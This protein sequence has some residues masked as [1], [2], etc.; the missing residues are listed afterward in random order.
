M[1]ELVFKGLLKAL[2]DLLKPIWEAAGVKLNAPEWLD[3]L[4]T[5]LKKAKS[6][7]FAQLKSIL[8]EL[9][10]EVT[11]ERARRAANLA[12][13]VSEYIV[14]LQ[15]Q[16]T[17]VRETSTGW[18]IDKLEL[19]TK[20]GA[21]A[22]RIAYNREPLT[23]WA[24]VND[25][26]RLEKLERDAHA[27]LTRWSIPEPDL[28]GV[29]NAAYVMCRATAKT[30]LIPMTEFYKS[31]R[32]VQVRRLLDSAGPHA[33]LSK[34]KLPVASFLHSV[35]RYRVISGDLP[36]AE[37]LGFQTGSSHEV[38]QKKGFIINGLDASSEYKVVCYVVQAEQ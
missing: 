17:L 3:E 24:N 9:D 25:V 21:G 37:R 8:D 16:G 28:L 15:A 13:I 22:A 2:G 23:P 19:Q 11:R 31:I 14:K 36:I 18:R 32:C 7:D 20:P 12:P 34:C 33:D 6:R 4:A 1:D 35:D 27:E 29:M 38:S 30:P 10:G 5:I 26:G